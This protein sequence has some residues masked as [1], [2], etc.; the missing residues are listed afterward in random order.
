[1]LREY[2]RCIPEIT[3]Y[4]IR[5]MELTSRSI[6]ERGIPTSGP[7]TILTFADFARLTPREREE[8]VLKAIRSSLAD[9][10]L[11]VHTLPGKQVELLFHQWY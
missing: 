8:S 2:I 4:T 11:S 10:D 6:V 7:E 1:M 9:A 5:H 3:C